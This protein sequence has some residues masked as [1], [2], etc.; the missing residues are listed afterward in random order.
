MHR[1]A[2]IC[3]ALVNRAK[4]NY[5]ACIHAGCDIEMAVSLRI[6]K[7]TR[8]I[9]EGDHRAWEQLKAL[10]KT[11][12][13]AKRV[14]KTVKEPAKPQSTVV[15][16]APKPA[17]T[18]EE[19]AEKAKAGDS[20]SISAL[21]KRAEYEDSAAQYDLAMALMESDPDEARKWLIRSCKSPDSMAALRTMAAKGDS[22]ALDWLSSHEE[23][24]MVPRV[25]PKAEDRAPIRDELGYIRPPTSHKRCRIGD[26]YRINDAKLQTGQK[27]TMVLIKEMKGDF[28]TVYV[29]T[30]EPGRHKSVRLQDPSIAGFA[31]PYVYVLTD[32][33][34]VYRKDGLAEYR[35]SLS[36]RDAKQ[37][38]LSV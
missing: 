16:P 27:N 15:K 12:P 34:R 5:G 37:F 20:V 25:T 23:K 11:D 2:G 21:R 18:R 13:D 14:L 4:H 8:Q 31:S 28:V 6:I 10:S 1:E 32:S 7:L 26:V 33:S 19:T 35:G 22:K 36:E 30:R 24:G 38:N 3:I 17:P 29:V 9:D